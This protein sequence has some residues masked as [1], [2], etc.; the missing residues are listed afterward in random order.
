MLAARDLGL[1][2]AVTIDQG[3]KET[4][5]PANKATIGKRA[6]LAALHGVYGKPVEGASPA[7]ESV[8]FSG[9]E[10]VVEFP[11]AGPSLRAVDGPLA[12]F[13]LAGADKQFHPATGILKGQVLTVTSPDV[14]QPVAVRYLWASYPEV[15]PLYSS[16]GLPV[17]PFRSD[18]WPKADVS[19]WFTKK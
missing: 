4:I 10:A 14:S 12:G 18:E 15:V 9:G 11:S 7:P 17:S 5:H 1:P 3:S 2:L 6:A 13:E 8:R 19:P 16:G